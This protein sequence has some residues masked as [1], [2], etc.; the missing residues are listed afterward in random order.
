M[1]D[2]RFQF[3]GLDELMA[4]LRRLPAELAGEGA[5]IVEAAAAGAF[6]T[7]HAGYPSRAGALKAKLTVT[8]TRSPFGARSVLK[9]TAKEAM[10]FE[11]GS[12]ARHTTLGAN[13]GSMPP[14]PLFTR[15]VM[16]KRRQMHQQHQAL[17]ERH[18]LTVSG[19]V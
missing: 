3:T 7:I 5:D 15:T 16:A 9:N 6:A 18:G 17:L 12:Q 11:H 1:S 13:R 2:T 19:L 10:W 14:N 8:H 4:Q